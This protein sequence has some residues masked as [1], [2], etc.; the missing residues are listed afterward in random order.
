MLFPLKFGKS[1]KGNR[2]K[3]KQPEAFFYAFRLFLYELCV[4]HLFFSECVKI[5]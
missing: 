4:K 5:V 3:D 2:A 1:D